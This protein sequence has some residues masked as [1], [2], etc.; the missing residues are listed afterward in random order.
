MSEHV[1]ATTALMTIEPTAYVAA[2]YESF[3]KTI[4]DA[5]TTYKDVS[6]VIT[7]KEGMVIAKKARAVFRDIRIGSEKR[8]VERKAPIIEIG[9]LLDSR[10]KEIVALVSPFEDKFDA[11]IA[12]E[13]KRL[14]DEK[15]AKIKAEA[16]RQSAIQLKIDEIKNAPLAALNSSADGTQVIIDGLHTVI[17]SEAL[18]GERFV[19]A[20]IAIKVSIEQLTQMLIGKRA[21]EHLAAQ[22][23]A[24]RIE[25]ERLAEIAAKEKLEAEA[26]AHAEQEVEAERIKTERAELDRQRAELAKMQEAIN[27]HN[28]R[29]QEEE[30]KAKAKLEAETQAKAAEDLKLA[31]MEQSA[32]AEA[33]AFRLT[34]HQ[35]EQ[36]EKAE[37]ILADLAQAKATNV[38]NEAKKVAESGYQ[39]ITDEQVITSIVDEFDITFDEACN[40]IIRVAENMRIAA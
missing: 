25:S 31:K 20:E 38:A 1:P 9:K 34:P 5:V 37:R 2:V 32:T 29:I 33:A 8:R 14:D 19:E 28:L 12:A 16:E 40:L 22:Q 27:A 26:K 21:Q 23:E 7:T 10:H 24:Q 30:A 15:A 35:I 36:A 3:Q 4:D 39:S 18:Y 17:P 6:Y 13:E 11:D